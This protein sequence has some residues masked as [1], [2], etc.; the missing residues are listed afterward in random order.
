MVQ[1]VV[2]SKASI[3]CHNIYKETTAENFATKISIKTQKSM[4]FEFLLRLNGICLLSS[5]LLYYSRLLVVY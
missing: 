4:L 5:A 3:L 1:L 2:V